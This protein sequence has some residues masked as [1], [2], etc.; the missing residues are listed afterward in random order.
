MNYWGYS[1]VLLG[2]AVVCVSVLYWFHINGGDD[3]NGSV[4]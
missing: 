4:D 1:I 3:E 2:Y